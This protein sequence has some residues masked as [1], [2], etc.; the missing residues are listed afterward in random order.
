MEEQ[1]L[2]VQKKLYVPCMA[3]KLRGMNKFDLLDAVLKR[4]DLLIHPKL[5]KQYRLALSSSKLSD[6]EKGN[7]AHVLQNTINLIKNVE[8]AREIIILSV[9]LLPKQ[10]GY[11]NSV[12]QIL[13]RVDITDKFNDFLRYHLETFSAEKG[14]SNPLITLCISLSDAIIKAAIEVLTNKP[15]EVF[16]EGTESMAEEIINLTKNGMF[17]TPK[18]SIR[19]KQTFESV[20]GHSLNSLLEEEEV[21]E[22]FINSEFFGNEH[23]Q[24]NQRKRKRG[25]SIESIF[26]TDS[27]SEIE[28]DEKNT[29]V[30]I[31]EYDNDEVTQSDEK[32]QSDVEEAVMKLF[33]E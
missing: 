18:I 6:V 11:A 14:H 1:I 8:L 26:S 27:E 10:S 24:I 33:L 21:D 3:N 31:E 20:V 29:V 32:S 19:P 13:E 22:I 7:L 25:S 12:I 16:Y 15:T 2:N 28:E 5:P 17:D 9:S 30:E 23:V 4:H